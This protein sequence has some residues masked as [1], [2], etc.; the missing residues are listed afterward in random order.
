MLRVVASPDV[1]SLHAV[2][3]MMAISNAEHRRMLKAYA[4]QDLDAA[5]ELTV[6]HLSSTVLALEDHL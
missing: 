3:D 6:H 5:R 4:E 2:P 1:A